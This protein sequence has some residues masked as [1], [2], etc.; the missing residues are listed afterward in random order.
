MFPEAFVMGSGLEK[1]ELGACIISNFYTSEA[2][3]F[4]RWQ[5]KIPTNWQFVAGCDDGGVCLKTLIYRLLLVQ[6]EDGKV[7]EAYQQVPPWAPLSAYQWLWLSS[8]TVS[9][10]IMGDRS[11]SWRF[12]VEEIGGH[13]SFSC[14]KTCNQWKIHE[15]KSS[16][17]DLKTPPTP[18]PSAGRYSSLL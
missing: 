10:G 11:H 3:M 16:I 1:M 6:V 13:C 4:T 5:W 14:E 2:R 17:L 7:N 8:L 9:N 12:L 15:T 18:G